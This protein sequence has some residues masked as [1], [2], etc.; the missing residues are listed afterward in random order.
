MSRAFNGGTSLDS[1]TM[2]VGTAPP[3]EGPITI[4]VL[5]KPSSA[6]FSG[7]AVQGRNGTTGIWS[8]LVDSGKLF[9][10][11]DF[12]SGGPSHGTG[13]CWF[14]VTKA[15][16][17]VIP[18][19]HKHDLTAATAWV[20]Q[21]DTSNAADG[22][23]PITNVMIGS[24]GSLGNTWRGNIAA[25][26]TWTSVL[27]DA[28]IEAACTLAASAL[29]A[30]TP[31]WMVRLNQ[32]STATAVTDDSGGGSTQ[33]AI[34]GTTVDTVNEPPGWSYTLTSTTPFS[35]TVVERYNVLNAWS[36]TVTESYRVTNAFSSSVTERYRVLN[37]WT[38]PV[39]ESYRVYAAFTASVVERYSVLAPW[40]F[41]VTEQYRVL[42]AWAKSTVEAYQVLAV[43]SKAV[44]D[45]YRVL[46]AWSLSAPESYR[47]LGAFTVS[48]VEQYRVLGAWSTSVVERYNA[49]SGTA[50]SFQIDE[51][52]RVLGAWS[53][54]IVERYDILGVAWSFSVAERYRVYA[55]W[56]R[57]IVERYNVGDIVPPDVAPDVT[58]YLTSF[59]VSADLRTLAT[60]R[61]GGYYATAY[62]DDNE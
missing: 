44:S 6:S 30:A 60:A 14:V 1:I 20:H 15:S 57:T 46:N 42:N 56:L 33:T 31:G 28:A 38:K 7:W 50:F 24:N 37:A 48:V 3:D 4:A 49:L 40:S 55:A 43:W 5:A 41:S 45:T 19:W 21:D 53:L 16:G 25:I 54:P 32:A 12:G 52:Y 62:L 8:L 51:R 13:W 27:S 39:A 18:R 58:A 59:A 2:S 23:G 61:L 10:E 36:K 17:S 35:K 9:C 11:N 34:S 47:V 22:S 26:A 29:K